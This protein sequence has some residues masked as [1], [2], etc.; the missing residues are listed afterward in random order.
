[1]SL[2]LPGCATFLGRGKRDYAQGLYLQASE[3]FA[4]HEE[5]VPYLSPS[6]QVDYGLYRGLSLMNLGD[7]RGAHRWLAF[8]NQVEKDNPGSMRPAQRLEI[9]RAITKLTHGTAQPGEAL[10]EP[11]VR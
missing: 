3:E 9:E 5:D 7:A 10:V 11:P 2:A 1:M 8:A 6:A 4:Q